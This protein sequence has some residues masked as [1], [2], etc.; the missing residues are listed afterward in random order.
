MKTKKYAQAV[1]RQ[2]AEAILA[3]ADRLDDS[4]ADAVKA[5]L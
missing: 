3:M 4:F 1:M 2:E 5:I